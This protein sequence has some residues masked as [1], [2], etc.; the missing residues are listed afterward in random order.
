MNLV[1]L[2]LRKKI[3]ADR[4]INLWLKKP[5]CLLIMLVLAQITLKL[6]ASFW[7]KVI[8]IRVSM[9][10]IRKALRIVTIRANLKYKHSR[11]HRR[12]GVAQLQVSIIIKA[13]L[14]AF[15][16]KK[17]NL[18]CMLNIWRIFQEKL[19][20]KNQV[21]AK[22]IKIIAAINK[23]IKVSIVT[24]YQL[25]ILLFR[26][27]STGPQAIHAKASIKVHILSNNKIYLGIIITIKLFIFKTILNPLSRSKIIRPI[28]WKIKVM[29]IIIVFIE[30]MVAILM[31]VERKYLK[32][33]QWIKLIRRIR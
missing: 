16:M 33:F 26:I 30:I 18:N 15:Q 14:Q 27:K 17:L 2:P 5:S 10:V 11:M 13:I 7:I 25:N 12:Q 1:I 21:F 4:V 6:S 19:S 22:R 3:A 23:I 20:H 29:K 32:H 8:I 31:L 9:L 28:K 24:I